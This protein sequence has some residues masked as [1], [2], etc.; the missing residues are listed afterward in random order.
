MLGELFI[1][2]SFMRNF[3]ARIKIVVVFFFS[4]FVA[5]FNRFVVLELALVA[6]LII[7]FA[8]QTP[9]RELVKRLLPVNVFILF[10][11]CFLP[12]TVLGETIF[13]L[14]PLRITFEGVRVAAQISIKSNA[15]MCL[16]IALVASTPVFTLGHALHELGLPKKMVYLFYFTY[17]YVDVIYR[18]YVRMINAM[19]MRGFRPKTNLHTYKSYAY[20]LGMILVKSFDRAQRVHAAMV[21]RCFNGNFYS[22]SEFSLKTKDILGLVFI[23]VVILILGILEWT[24]II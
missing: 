15:I 13:V 9:L 21:C 11:W 16:L 2:D 8:A 7:V 1:Y 5:V 6:G 12:F 17:R 4:V 22:L 14:G 3:D 19:K 18:E 20:M 23:L 24:I 10:L